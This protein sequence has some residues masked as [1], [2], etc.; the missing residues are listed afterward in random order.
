MMHYNNAVVFITELP[1]KKAC[2]EY[3]HTRVDQISN[4]QVL[5]PFD[6]EYG[7]GY[8]LPDGDRFRLELFIDGAMVTKDVI[9]SGEGIL[10]RFVDSDK[11]FKFVS[12]DHPSVSD[13]TSADNGGIE[14]R[15]YRE[16][17]VVYIPAPIYPRSSYGPHYYGRSA[18]D[19]VLRSRGMTGND[20]PSGCKGVFPQGADNMTF[21]NSS[22]SV[23]DVSLTA[24]CSSSV[25]MDSDLSI[26]SAS[27]CLGE[28]GATVEGSKSRQK[29]GTT[30]WEG[31]E[32]GKPLVFHFQLRGRATNTPEPPKVKRAIE[33]PYC[34]TFSQETAKFCG[35]CGAK[36]ARVFV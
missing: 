31:D 26:T 34:H 27:A 29:F 25:T 28:V 36:F 15:L 20:G 8:K 17:K 5:L 4:V 32:M 35:E 22:A 9:L 21:C 19:G 12:A 16:R 7:I 33:C 11:K 30:T 14:V 6:T 18:F 24:N 2:R 13:P 10:E 3:N 1:S 23:G